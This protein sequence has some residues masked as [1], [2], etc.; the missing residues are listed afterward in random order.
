MKHKLLK[1]IS[2]LVAITFLQQD[3]SPIGYQ[4]LQLKRCLT[5]D[6]DL[7][8]PRAFREKQTDGP[9]PKQGGQPDFS[10]RGTRRPVATQGTQSH[11]IGQLQVRLRELQGQIRE[12]PGLIMPLHQIALV[13][14]RLG[15]YEKA[16]RYALRAIREARALMWRHRPI[17]K[18][19]AGHSILSHI[20]LEWGRLSEASE[21]VDVVLGLR[22]D[23]YIAYYQKC[24]VLLAMGKPEEALAFA[25]EAIKYSPESP[26]GYSLRSTA[27]LTWGLK[28]LILEGSGKAKIFSER[29]LRTIGDKR[30]SSKYSSLL[31]SWFSQI[32]RGDLQE[33]S[34]PKRFKYIEHPITEHT[35]GRTEI[36]EIGTSKT[37]FPT[38]L[39]HG[40][41]VDLL[42]GAL[43]SCVSI[44]KLPEG[45]K[46]EWWPDDT[47]VSY[48]PVGREGE[49]MRIVVAGMERGKALTA[50]PSFGP[51][52][53]CI[54]ES[55]PIPPEHRS[56]APIGL[57]V[58]NKNS[59]QPVNMRVGNSQNGFI[60]MFNG[61]LLR[62]LEPIE[63][64]QLIWLAAVEGKHAYEDRDFVYY[65]YV[66]FPEWQKR[67]YAQGPVTAVYLKV[68][69][70]SF[71]AIQILDK[72]PEEARAVSRK[73]A[74]FLR[75]VRRPPAKA[76]ETSI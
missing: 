39:N 18:E 48:I 6:S 3:A 76:A 28:I 26:A 1:L 58:W 4:A 75:Q 24:L 12:K 50:Y 33:I 13:Y 25:E 19:A 43:A 10:E 65:S 14:L 27:L 8:R 15:E 2:I 7:L 66:P 62:G 52:V 56:L 46:L 63:R 22:P 42:R 54:E 67:L 20:Y 73:G 41:V 57:T 72:V 60:S 30:K 9:S 34:P 37:F 47:W 32:I 51:G 29:Q 64:E 61:D 40:E 36:S 21:E 17:D 53:F 55:I 68:S 16:E 44:G 11:H 49:L 35:L 23:D 70:Q 74:P 69:K 59:R 38:D 31:M 45:K 71:R 5:P